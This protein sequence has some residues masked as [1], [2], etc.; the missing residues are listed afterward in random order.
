MQYNLLGGTGIE[1]S[2]IC[3][4]TMTFGEQNSEKEAHE[5]LDY[6]IDQ[7]INFIDTAELYSVPG[8]KETQGSTERFI[9]TWLM[10]RQNR[11]KLIVSSKI[12]GPSPGLLY[13][14]NPINFSPQSIDEAIEGSLARLQTDYIDLYQLHWP[15]RKTNRFGQL[16]YI[17]DKDEQW[18]DNFLEVIHSLNKFMKSG[19]IRFWGLSNETPWGVMRFLKLAE[20][21]GFPKPVT[22]QNPYSLLNRTYEIGLSEIS[23]RERIGLLAYS[24]LGFGLLS[25]KYHDNSDV[26]KSRLKLFPKLARYSNEAAYHAT[27]KYVSLANKFGLKPGQMALAF[28]NSRAF[29]WSTIIGSTTMDQLKENIKSIDVELPNEVL[30]EIESIHKQCANPAP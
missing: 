13:I 4:G 7:G 6:A 9:G 8:R 19:V 26:T 18:D 11:D 14:R 16:G 25:G 28:V 5:Q 22:I 2:K 30:D 17:Y 3:L 24:P 23:M 12:V 15:E 1:I 27:E 20:E 21:N 10:N 29:L